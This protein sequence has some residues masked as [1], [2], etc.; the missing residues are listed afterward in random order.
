MV[1]PSTIFGE[2]SVPQDTVVFSPR[3]SVLLISIYPYQA[4]VTGSHNTGDFAE[5]PRLG[6][7]LWPLLALVGAVQLFMLWSRNKS[8]SFNVED[9]MRIASEKATAALASLKPGFAVPDLVNALNLEIINFKP[10][11][12]QVP[13]SSTGFLN[14]AADVIKMAP[15]GTII[16][17]GGHTDNTGDPAANLSLSQQRAEAVRNYLVQRGV[18]ASQLTA[19]GYGDSRPVAG[20]NTDQGHFHNRRIEFKAPLDFRSNKFVKGLI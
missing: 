10:G 19:K 14:K 4:L 17:I 5:G 18:Q 8:T 20:N 6:R 16:E 2:E 9:Q 12:A 11:S 7:M 1:H 13:D 3:L 15:S